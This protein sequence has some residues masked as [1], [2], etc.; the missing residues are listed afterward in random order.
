[1]QSTDIDILNLPQ[2][3][4]KCACGTESYVQRGGDALSLSLL[5]E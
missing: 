2:T 1:M 3:S 4:W 5:Y